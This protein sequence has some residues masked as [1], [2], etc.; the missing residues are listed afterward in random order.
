[1]AKPL[2]TAVN[3]YVRLKL[4]AGQASPGAAEHPGTSSFPQFPSPNA[5]EADGQKV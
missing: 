4:E 5:T 2:L 3:Q 1:M